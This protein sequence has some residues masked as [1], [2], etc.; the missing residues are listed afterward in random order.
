MIRVGLIGFGTGGR[1][2]HA[3]L[4]HALD[5][6]QLAAVA[7]RRADAVEQIYPEVAVTS[8]E[9]L[10]DDPA[11]ELVVIS[12]PNE[13][14]FPL[15]RAALSAGKHVVIDK[16]FTTQSAEGAELDLLA[17]NSE[18]V[19][20]AYHNRRW[21]G[22]FLTAQSV[23]QSG[24]LGKVMQCELRWDRYRPEVT[25]GWRDIPDIGSGIVADLGPHLFDQA[26]CLFGKPDAIAADIEVQRAGAQTDDYFEATLFYGKARVILSAGRLMARAR[27]RFALHGTTAS[28]HKYGLDPQEAVLREGG[29]PGTHVEAEEDWGQINYGDARTEAVPTI[30]GDYREFYRQIHGAIRDGGPPPVPMEDVLLGLKLMEMARQSAR[31]GRRLTL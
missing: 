13:S 2:F 25:E 24:V 5:E 6:Y 29:A 7:T 18:L 31:E 26:L 14:H 28:F 23:L 8:P 19:L 15:A 3:P 1:A 17:Q 9:A 11:I 21:D 20:C 12:T 16:P 4:I 27:P 30:K 10:I 22:D